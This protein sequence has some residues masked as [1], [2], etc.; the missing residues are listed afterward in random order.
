MA[1]RMAKQKW[2]IRF[3]PYYYLREFCFPA[4]IF[5]VRGRS[6]PRPRL[7]FFDQENEDDEDDLVA[8]SAALCPSEVNDFFAPVHCNPQ[9]SSF[10]ARILQE[11]GQP[12]PP[13]SAAPVPSRGQSCPRSFGFGSAALRSSAVKF[14]SS[15]AETII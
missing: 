7:S 1:L 2:N 4:Q 8:A 10:A 15:I 6:R 5:P 14:F 13:V 11:R 3:H 9:E 12:C